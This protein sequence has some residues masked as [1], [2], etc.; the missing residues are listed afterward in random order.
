LNLLESIILYIRRFT[1]AYT[2]AQ[3]SDAVII[4]LINLF[5]IQDVNARIQLFDFKKTYQFQTR[6]GVDQYNM[7]M[8][9][10][11][12][13]PGNITIGS[14]P[15]YQGF[16]GNCY[17]NGVQVGFTTLKQTFFR[18]WPNFVQNLRTVAQGDGGSSY[19]FTIPIIGNTVP[20][21]PPFQGL[22]RGHVDIAGIIATGTNDDPILGTAPNVN[23]P[24]TSTYP[25]V[26]ITSIDSNGNT[27][28]VSD[29]GQ[30]LSSDVNKGMLINPGK[31]PTGNQALTGGYSD[32]S[33]VIDYFSGDVFVNFP[34]SIPE[35]NDINVQCYY[36][37]TGLPRSILFYNNV[38]TLRTIPDRSYLVEMDAYLTPAAFL[39]TENAIPYGYMAE[40]I[41]LGAARKFFYSTGDQEQLMFYE[42]IFREQEQLVHVRSERQFTATKT[43]T[44][45]SQK[46]YGQFNTFYGDGY[47]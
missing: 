10:V 12:T 29:S 26:F 39:V 13:E 14:Y 16:T 43:P 5:L 45:Y 21:N 20:Q 9:D 47:A 4:D 6:P 17:I 3:L 8:Y 7:P 27:V 11:Q 40:Y 38:I 19:S 15:V 44:I 31:P 37:N 33:N 35:G 30:Y 42:P 25:A 41:A 32:T 22:L 23:V 24:V 34:V 46:P 2:D 1:K 28:V 18:A 36:F